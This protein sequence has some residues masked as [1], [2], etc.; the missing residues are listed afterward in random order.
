M[1]KQTKITIATALFFIAAIADVYAIISSN[2]IVE[3]YAKPM[4]LTLLA[5]VY[6]VSANKPVF[7]YVLGM[8]FCFVGDVLLM[9]KG[10]NF[11]MYGLAAFLVGHIVYIKI[12]VSFLPKD[13]TFKMITSAFP[14]VIL[15]GVLMYFIYPNLNEML[16][17]VVVYGVTI[18]TFGSVAFLNYRIEKSTENLW[19][20]I[21]AILFILSDSLIAINKF[22]EP[23]DLYGVSIMI[24]YILAQFL[25]CKAMI[26]KSN[27]IK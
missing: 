18:S 3:T 4:L 17:P 5:V 6:L 9:F 21:G 1:T 27:V 13:L 11:F 20:F 12:T 24:T 8:F 7:W 26:M 2:E 23:N 16:L 10:A 14:F 22:Y 15:F 19:L 25:I